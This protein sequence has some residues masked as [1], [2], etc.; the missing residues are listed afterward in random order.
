MG[1]S[2]RDEDS[3]PQALTDGVPLHTM[4]LFQPLLKLMVDVEHLREREIKKYES[5]RLTI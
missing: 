5:K 3:I 1:G 4:L 2:S